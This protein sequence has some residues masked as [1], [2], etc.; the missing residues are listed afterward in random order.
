VNL[1]EAL[2]FWL[3][4]ALYAAAFVS[5]LFLVAFKGRR[6]ARSAGALLGLGFGVH[7]VVV[8]LRWWLA[9]HLPVGN[10]YELNVTGTWIGMLVVLGVALRLPQARTVV[11]GALPPVLLA[12]GIGVISETSVAPL[13]PAYDSPWLVVHIAFAFLAFGCFVL[14]FGAGVLSLFGRRVVRRR[15]AGLLPPDEELGSFEHRAVSA[16]F[17]L[18]ALMIIT[19]ALW[20]NRLWGSYWSWDDPVQTWSFVSLLVYALYLHVHAFPKRRGPAT[21]VLAVIGL[22]FVMMS[23]WGVQYILPTVHN[24]NAL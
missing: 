23:F 8:G 9:A 13:S 14:A 19:G 22:L 6:W 20:A 21:S 12:M 15:L 4:T 10:T 3:A 5:L 1:S 7:T 11:I 2:F 17:V 24:F 16:G 18:E